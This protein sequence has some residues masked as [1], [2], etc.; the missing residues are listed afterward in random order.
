M[1]FRRHVG[2]IAAGLLAAAAALPAF[3]QSA[4]EFFKGKTLTIYVGLSAG[5]GYDQN[6]RLL[7]KYWG[8]CI[9]GQ[10]TVVV[11][12][13]TGGGGLVM[14]NFVANVAPKDGLHVAAP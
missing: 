12:N 2:L 8:R 3:A 14:A 4:E 11:R 1:P 6:A 5:G 13:M 7:A 10:P 9:P